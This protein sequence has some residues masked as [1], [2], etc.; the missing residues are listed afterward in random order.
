MWP[1]KGLSRPFQYVG[2]RVLRLSATPHAVAA[3]LAAGVV[4]SLTPFIGFHFLIAFAIAYL[5]SGNMLAAGLGTAVGNPLT[6]P[7]IWAATW[8]VG[9][10]M[11]GQGDPVGGAVDLHRLW[12]QFGIAHIWQPILKPMLVGAI[13]IAV[14]SAVL[15]YPA[16][17]VAVERFQRQRRERLSARAKAR[18]TEALEGTSV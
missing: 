9:N 18:L 1:R 10:R 14:I 12:H 13:P 8:E 17:Y 16:T 5:I 3:G 11:V 4:S 15:V 7:F 2:K 6:F